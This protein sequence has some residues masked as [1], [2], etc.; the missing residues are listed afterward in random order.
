M[1]HLEEFLALS[2]EHRFRIFFQ[3]G[4]VSA[5]GRS[6]AIGQAEE[7]LALLRQGREELRAIGAVVGTPGLF[8][9]LARAYAMLGQP[10]ED[11]TASPRLR[12]SSRP[13]TSESAKPSCCIG[14][15]ATC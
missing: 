1:V 4:L 12:G 5:G 10:A 11:A 6:I 13:P 14:C 15:R 7:G 3:L 8:T 2:T 9:W